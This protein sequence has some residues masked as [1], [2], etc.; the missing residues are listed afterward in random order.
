MFVFYSFCVWLSLHLPRV[1][2]PAAVHLSE[3]APADDPMHAEVVHGQLRMDKGEGLQ[4]RQGRSETY[5][6]PTCL[7]R[8]ISGRR[9]C[10]VD[11]I[12]RARP[13]EK[14]GVGPVPS[15]LWRSSFVVRMQTRPTTGLCENVILAGT[16]KQISAFETGV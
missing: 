15:E 2:L 16:Q 14:E 11:Q 1:G 5:L 8:F 7:I 12:T 4:Q 13:P 6:Y 9:E 3:A 10:C